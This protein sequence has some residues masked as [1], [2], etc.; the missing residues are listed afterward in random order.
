MDLEKRNTAKQVKNMA[1]T[2][3]TYVFPLVALRGKVVFPDTQTSFDAGRL[4]SLTAISRASEKDMNLFVSLQK[5][6]EKEQ[7]AAKDVCAVGTVVKIKQI[8][9]LPSGNLRVS[10]EGLYRA[11]RKKSTKRMAAFMPS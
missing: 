9:K 8:A 7:I 6:A 2:K 10:V 3:K 4:I 11:R 1:R 5:D